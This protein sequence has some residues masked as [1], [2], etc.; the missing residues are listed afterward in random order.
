MFQ[1]QKELSLTLTNIL[2]RIQCPILRYNLQLR[3]D[4]D[5]VLD[6]CHVC[7]CFLFLLKA[8]F[9]L[10]RNFVINTVQYLLR[11]SVHYCLKSRLRLRYKK[12]SRKI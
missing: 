4:N 8:F 10:I 2:L 5:S 1:N 3:F 11:E 12:I 6:I 9:G 7:I